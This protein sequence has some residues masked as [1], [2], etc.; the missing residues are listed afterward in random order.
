MIVSI[1]MASSDA[2]LSPLATRMPGRASTCQTLAMNGAV[3]AVAPAGTRTAAGRRAVTR[4]RAGS[5][6]AR[7]NSALSSS[8]LA[9]QR[10]FS[11]AN[12]ADCRAR[13]AAMDAAFA[14]RNRVYEP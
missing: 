7:S 14:A 9:R 3:T 12:A 2:S 5:G 8:P 10:S 13:N 11:A 6:S 1:F 4:A